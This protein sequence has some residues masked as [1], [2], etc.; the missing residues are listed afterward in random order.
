MKICGVVNDLNE[1]KEVEEIIK[2]FLIKQR[3]NNLTS[4]GKNKKIKNPNLNFIK[5]I[6]DNY[7]PSK[8]SEIKNF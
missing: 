4:V 7:I 5:K 8:N 2:V 6:T 1:A 3:I